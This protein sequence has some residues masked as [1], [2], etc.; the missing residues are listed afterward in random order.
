MNSNIDSQL[1][2]RQSTDS[3]S[4]EVVR[5]ERSQIPAACVISSTA[6]VDDP[7]FA[8]I[9]PPAESERLKFLR[10]FGRMSM[11]YGLP[12][13]H[14]YTTAEPMHGIAL[15]MPPGQYPLN[16]W[17]MLAVGL[18]QVPFRI[19]FGKFI[20]FSQLFQTVEHW[21]QKDVPTP[22]WYLS[23]LAVAPQ[24]QGRGIGGQLIQPILQQADRD[25]LPC[26]LETTTE[27]AVR[28]YQRHGFVIKREEVLPGFNVPIWTMLRSPLPQ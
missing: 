26:Y 28:F 14:L 3:L 27:G 9:L 15:W 24:S 6:F 17:R 23:M 10:W 11:D 12:L 1:S 4:V 2:S 13:G 8:C 7:L 16:P 21:H 22:H 18:Y 19:G 5:L 20:Q 25:G